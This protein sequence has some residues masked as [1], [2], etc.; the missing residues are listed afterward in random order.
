MLN[1][2]IIWKFQWY[3]CCEQ[4]LGQLIF[5]V[6]AKHMALLPYQI[7]FTLFDTNL[8]EKF[9]FKFF[10]SFPEKFE[11]S[12][13]HNGPTENSRNTLDLSKHSRLTLDYLKKGQNFLSIK[14][15]L[16]FWSF[17]ELQYFMLVSIF[18]ASQ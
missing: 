6:F 13:N 8:L 11:F 16:R 14:F 9:T 18:K 10:I 15:F 5:C 12:I 2:R 7:L 4:F 3:F 17:C 1:M